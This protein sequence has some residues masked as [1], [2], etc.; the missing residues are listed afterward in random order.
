M[1]PMGL[2]PLEVSA[3]SLV[4]DAFGFDFFVLFDIFVQKRKKEMKHFR[5][6]NDQYRKIHG[7]HL[8]P[9]MKS[10]KITTCNQLDLGTL[11]S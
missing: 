5:T 1:C 7:I 10:R 6:I 11:G 2:P 8:K 9:I 3:S 4:L